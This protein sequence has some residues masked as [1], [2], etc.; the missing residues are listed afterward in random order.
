M[1]EIRLIPHSPSSS[2][3]IQV[4][5][6]QDFYVL[7]SIQFTCNQSMS[8]QSQWLI[9]NCTN[10]C[11]NVVIRNE[12]ETNHNELYIPSQLLP[13]GKYQLILTVTIIG[14]SSSSLRQSQSQSLY[15]QITPTGI[16]ANLVPLG[17]SMIT[18]G[19]EQDLELDPGK[20]STDPDGYSFNVSV[21]SLSIYLLHDLLLFSNIYSK[22]WKYQYFCRIY[23]IYHIHEDFLTHYHQIN[24]SVHLSCLA[25][26]SGRK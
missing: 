16:T 25:N 20:Y 26:R 12:I 7:S 24:D 3:P 13:Y 9:K 19:H 23:G 22:D 10:N 2:S 17:T 15:I 18:C 4:R 8:I 11:S 14:Q 21:S 6:S 5:R 1:H